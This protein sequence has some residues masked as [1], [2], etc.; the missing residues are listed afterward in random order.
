MSLSRRRRSRLTVCNFVALTPLFVPLAPAHSAVLLNGPPSGG[1]YVCADV[2]G[3][4]NAPSNKVQAW[5]CHAGPNQ[6]FALES[7][8]SSASVIPGGLII[9]ALGGTMCLSAASFAEGSTIVVE[10]CTA[11]WAGAIWQ[12]TIQGQLQELHNLQQPLCLD[13]TNGMNGITLVLNS[14]NSNTNSQQWTIE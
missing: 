13:A 9:F 14:C 2:A 4:S 1:P 6:Q 7:G 5:S 12:Y 3:D 10:P 8:V 11:P